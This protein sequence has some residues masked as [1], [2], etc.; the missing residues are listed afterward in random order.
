LVLKKSGG[1]VTSANLDAQTV[2]DAQFLVSSG[3]AKSRNAAINRAVQALAAAQRLITR[4][5][6]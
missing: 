2:V 5:E 3:W 1:T 4:S 6:N